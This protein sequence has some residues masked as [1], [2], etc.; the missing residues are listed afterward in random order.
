MYILFF[1]RECLR[2]KGLYVAIFA[3]TL[4]ILPHVIWLIQHDFFSF[5]YMTGR[6]EITL[7]NTPLSL[8]KFGRVIFPI[9]FM[10]DQLLSVLPCL[11]LFVLAALQAKNIGIK[12]K[13]KDLSEMA[14]VITICFAPIFLQSLMGAVSNTRV[15]GMWGSIMVSFFGIFLFYM[16]PVKFNKDTFKF[17]FKCVCSLSLIW[18]IAMFLFSQ[19]HTKFHI[20]FPYQTIIPKIVEEWDLETNKAELKYIGGNGE[21][22]YKI[23]QYCER[24]V[25]VILETFGYKNPWLDEK[26]ILNSGSIVFGKTEE[27]LKDQVKEDIILLPENYKIKSRRY[28]YEITNKLGKTKHFDFYYAII[29]PITK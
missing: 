12:N 4:V 15:M 17:L 16:F 28:D 3:G 5:A 9:K 29:P 20:G 24:P 22:V 7:H 27:D 13:D 11:L 18:M 26:D 1:K 25:T 6:T 23:K 19:L 8:L 2:K 10:L 14:F 21:Y